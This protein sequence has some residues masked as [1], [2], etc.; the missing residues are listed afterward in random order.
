MNPQRARS[1]PDPL[2][3]GTT[4]LAGKKF[5]LSHTNRVYFPE[6]RLTKGHVLRYYHDVA[7]YLLPHLRDRPLALERFPHGV[8][9][10]SFFQK[11]ASP[12]FP[13]WIRTF[14]VE[15]KR[16]GRT[17]YHVL[18]DDV[19]DLVYLANLGT[20]TF[21]AFLSRID[22][23]EHPD[24]VIL[25]V[26]P[27]DVPGLTREQA[28]S[29]ARETA[30]LLRE[31]LAAF[32]FEPKVKTSGKRGVHLG[33]PLDRTRTYTE[34]R[35][36]LTDLF[37]S[38]VARRPDLVTLAVRKNKRQGRVY[39]DALRMAFGA[40]V[41]PP[42]TLRATPTATVSMPV[43]WEELARLPHSQTYTL[44]NALER[45]EAV[46]DLWRDLVPPDGS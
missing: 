31:A 42:Y 10:D 18:V 35:R 11:N 41:V 8:E 43:T 16:A 25:D 19:A 4:E 24:L 37:R 38:L 20:I 45:L 29:P 17:D 5:R 26:D 40:T 34:V 14:P 44:C 23:L 9:A 27:P 15:Y 46:G 21:H 36:S 33:L 22:D 32:G 13:K 30:F 1:C 6:V 2:P 12:Y 7:S 39:L 28:F 3:S